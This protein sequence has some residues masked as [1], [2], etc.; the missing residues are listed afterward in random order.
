[1][2]PKIF[3]KGMF[4]PCGEDVRAMS[5]MSKPSFVERFAEIIHSNFGL[6]C[7][8]F[9]V[10]FTFNLSSSFRHPNP[11]YSKGWA[12]PNFLDSNRE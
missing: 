11:K 3:L 4:T 6:M 12:F 7:P 1:M 10:F 9:S 5:W 8:A 2:L